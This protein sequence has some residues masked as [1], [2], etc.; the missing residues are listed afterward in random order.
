MFKQP[1]EHIFFLN[2][3]HYRNLIKTFTV[4]SK[5]F[6]EVTRVTKF[7][8]NPLETIPNQEEAGLG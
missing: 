2:Q 3:S 6:W 1:V 5:I 4:V 8:T 7:Q